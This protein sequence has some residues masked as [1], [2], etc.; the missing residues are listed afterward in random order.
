VHGYESDKKV[1][2]HTVVM[3]EQWWRS[4]IRFHV[5][6]ET[7]EHIAE[8]LEPNFVVFVLVRTQNES[9]HLKANLDVPQFD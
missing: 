6:A 8:T 9:N 5:F 7:R 1:E 4:N 2:E 3:S